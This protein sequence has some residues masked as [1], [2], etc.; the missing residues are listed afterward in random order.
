MRGLDEVRN[1]GKV[2]RREDL[3]VTVVQAPHP[4]HYYS[5][6]SWSTGTDVV[7]AMYSGNRYEV[8]CKYTQFVNL[9]SRRVWPRV[10]LE[11][12]AEVRSPSPTPTLGGFCFG[13]VLPVFFVWF[14]DPGPSVAGG[15]ARCNLAAHARQCCGCQCYVELPVHLGVV[16]VNCRTAGGNCSC[17][18]MNHATR[19]SAAVPVRDGVEHRALVPTGVVRSQPHVWMRQVAGLQHAFQMMRP[20]FLGATWPET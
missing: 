6:F 11:A 8:E 1:D 3:G 15:D 19:R 5:L 7:V 18:Q 16:G 14:P 2:T 10:S 17:G 12:L 13:L 20:G 4:L 9:H